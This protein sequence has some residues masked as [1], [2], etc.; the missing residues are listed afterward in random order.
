VHT[1][2]PNGQPLEDPREEKRA[3]VELADKSARI[4]V[5]VR[6]RLPRKDTR[7]EVGEDVRVGS[8]EC[9]DISFTVCVCRSFCGSRRQH[10]DEVWQQMGRR[11]GTKFGR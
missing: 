9:S 11:N 6:G 2:I 5:R 8:M 3:S 7:A 1:R 10:I 4:V